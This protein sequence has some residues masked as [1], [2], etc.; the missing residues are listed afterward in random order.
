VWFLVCF[1]FFLFFVSVAS[2]SQKYG[3]V[4]LGILVPFFSSLIILLSRQRPFLIFLSYPVLIVPSF[5]S[6]LCIRMVERT[7]LPSINSL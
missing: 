1:F 3:S 7:Q 2:R 4:F 5:P 6:P